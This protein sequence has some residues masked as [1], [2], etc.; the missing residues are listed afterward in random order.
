MEAIKLARN[1]CNSLIDEQNMVSEER[2]LEILKTMSGY[3]VQYFKIPNDD[4]ELCS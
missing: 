2:V 3:F 1:T 4:Y